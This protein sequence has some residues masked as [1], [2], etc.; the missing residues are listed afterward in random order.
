VVLTPLMRH[1]GELGQPFDPGLEAGECE[2]SRQDHAAHD[3]GRARLP[4]IYKKFT[5]I[6]P[7]LDKLGNGG[8]GISWN[9]GHEVDELRRIN[10]TVRTRACQ[11]PPR[12]DTA[13]DAAEMILTL[14][15]ETNGHVAVK[16]WDALSR[17]PGAT[18]PIWRCPRARQDPLPRRAGAAAQDHFLAHLV[19][20]GKRRSQSYAGYTNVHEL[21][22]WR[23]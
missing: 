13:I 21:I 4:D 2:P 18:T 14:A 12:L 9:T 16:A 22:P 11:G 8:K 6:G 5:S 7:L 19:G 1:P 15:P 10:R 17:S 3:G 23:T 20:P